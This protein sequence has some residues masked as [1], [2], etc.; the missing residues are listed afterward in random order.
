MK[1]STAHTA[2]FC[3][4]VSVVFSVISP[5]TVAVAANRPKS[6]SDLAM[7]RPGEGRNELNPRDLRANG[8]IHLGSQERECLGL[9]N[10]YRAQY[11]L[12]P[13]AAS[14]T[15]I[16]SARWMSQDMAQHG[17]FGHTDSMGRNPFSRMAAFRYGYYTSQGENIA[18]GNSDAQST[19]IQWQNSP[20]HN[21]NM[22]NPNYRVIGIGRVE[23][24]GSMY[25]WYWTTDFGGYVDEVLR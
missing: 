15:L 7:E 16:R 10:Q 1:A 22:L 2:V 4:F 5:T 8:A 13:L 20:E 6:A 17:Y 19:F 18:A 3:A 11:G 25:V 23:L 24:Q 12:A 21:A 9:I 14:P